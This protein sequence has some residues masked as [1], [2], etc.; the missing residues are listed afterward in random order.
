MIY[1]SKQG[2][3]SDYP[4]RI[5]RL[6][7]ELGLTQGRLAELMGV[8]FASVNRWENGQ[9]R[10]SPLA[11]QQIVRAEKWGI[12]AL[13][14]GYAGE[15]EV[16]ESVET[17]AGKPGT[18]PE[19]DF[20]ADP[21]IVQVVAEGRRLTYDEAAATMTELSGW[22]LVPGVLPELW[23]NPEITL[24]ELYQ[25]FSGNHVVKVQKNG[26]EEPITIPKVERPVM[27]TA[28]HA[29]V[30]NGKL[31]LTSS[32]ASIYAED[33]PTGILTE[34]AVLQAPPQPI[35]AADILPAKLP[36]AWGEETTTALVISIALCKRAGKTLPWGTVREAIDGAIRARFLERT[37]D[38]GPW[39]CDYTGAQ[40]VELRVPAEQVSPPSPGRPPEPQP[41]VMVAEAELRPNE[42]QDL[43]DQ[44]G[45]IRKAAAGLDLKFH[46][47]IEL[48]SSPPPP[49]ED[50]V[51]KINQML[52]KIS[53][54][55]KLR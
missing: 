26:Y 36:E 34:D 15:P 33:I 7:I 3:P 28:V 23:R 1:A 55:L 27:D 22:L 13:G 49:P 41:R 9:S 24:G 35:P 6:R 45:V 2:I 30:K 31:W 8:S 25:Y 14:S 54:G 18:P 19:I 53:S 10:P 20:S 37:P 50:T 46:L 48:G 12:E 17:Y 39:P 4:M 5:K 42:I 32:T 38:S 16:R 43:A 40:T 47:R 29:A 21:G 52:Q 51:A 44:I 11:W